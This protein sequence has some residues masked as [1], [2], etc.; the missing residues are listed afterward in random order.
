M[1]IDWFTVIA[2]LLNFLVL[3]WLL[4]RFLFKPIQHAI[5]E[6]ERKISSQ[7]RDAEDKVRDA[8]IEQEEFRKKNELFDQEKKGLMDNVIAETNEE[9]EIL[10]DKIRTEATD[11][12][13]NLEKA[14][15]E[16]QENLNREIEQKIQLE[17]FHIAG[18]A[19]GDLASQSLEKESVNIFLKRVDNLQKEEKV[20]FIEAFTPGI[21]EPNLIKV[22]SAFDLPKDKQTEIKKRVNEVLGINAKYQFKISPG[23]VCGIELTSNGYKLGWSFSEYLNSFKKSISEE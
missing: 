13:S 11:L 6:R 17:V 15:N 14:L 3:V 12:Q 21:G 10:L 18:K 22:Q 8:I 2:Q 5:D 4:K 20:K 23:L 9:R 7:L 19:L 1:Q 16:I